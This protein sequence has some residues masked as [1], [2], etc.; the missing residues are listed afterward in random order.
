MLRLFLRGRLVYYLGFEG[1]K[2]EGLTTVFSF[3]YELALYFGIGGWAYN[4]IIGGGYLKNTFRRLFG[5]SVFKTIPSCFLLIVVSLT[6][7]LFA[8]AQEKEWEAIYDASKDSSHNIS[9]ENTEK[10]HTGSGYIAGW[11]EDGSYVDINIEI[12]ENGNYTL[13]IRYSAAA[14]QAI[15]YLSIDDNYEW[16]QLHFDDTEEW[17]DWSTVSIKELYFKEGHHTVSLIFDASKGSDNWLNYDQLMVVQENTEDMIDLETMQTRANKA[18]ASL[19]E[20]FWNNELKM[21]NNAYECND[22]NDQFHYWWQAHAIDTLI[23]RYERT[24]DDKYLHQAA[25]LFDGIV[26]R[27]QGITND[28]YDDMLWMGLAVN[29]LHDYTQDGEHKE[30]VLELWEDIK[31]GWNDEN[32]GGIAWNKSQLDYKNTPSNAPAVILAVRLYEKFENETDLEWA[33]NIYEWQK[34]TLV[35]PDTGIVW[36]GIN[37]EGDGNVDKNWLFTYNQGVFIGA[38]LELYH[39]T[40]ESYYLSAAEK[41]IESTME[42][43]TDANGI[44]QENDV[45]DGG[46]FKGI[47]IRYLSQMALEGHLKTDLTDFIIEN[48]KSAWDQISAEGDILFGASWLNPPDE[49]VELSQQLSGTILMEQAALLMMASDKFED[50][51]KLPSTATHQFNYMVIGLMLIG[52][53]ILF[54]FIKN[55]KMS[56]GT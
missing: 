14:G 4:N 50:G 45:G 56:K 43:F 52:T 23:D 2:Y 39:I 54:W 33:E 35:D 28:F 16:D 3:C 55:W 17:D 19:Y 15:R 12:P 25:E 8:I 53:A 44:I 32:G 49:N 6:P 11:N 47:L 13:V 51:G 5:V 41:T 1:L 29:R 31:T 10:G 21:F 26:K 20:N 48:A 9:I 40:D 46:L 7:G 24:R 37:R 22:C 30:A 42:E 34:E 18:Q 27:N 38:S 36:D